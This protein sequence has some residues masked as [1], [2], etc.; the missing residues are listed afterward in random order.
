MK[1]II[2]AAF[3]AASI[4]GFSASA[5]QSIDNPITQAMLDVYAQ[6][7]A[8]NPKDAEL[9]FRRA[10]EY[11]KF[12]QYLRAL[13][14]VDK[15]L[16]YA[17]EKNRDLR[18]QAYMLRADI[19][20]MLNK[21]QE[22]LADFSQAYSID[23]TSFMA[24]YQKANEE[25]EL[26]DYT[27]A[28]ADYTRLRSTNPRSVEALTGLARVA[29]KE[30]NLGLA[31]EYMDGAVEMMSADSD[32]YVRRASVRRMQ[33]NNTGAVEDLLMAI[34]IDNN[35]RAFEE[36]I[37]LANVDY[38]AVISG[39]STSISYAPQQGMLYYIRG[40]IAQAHDH[41]ISA[42]EDYRR[43]IDQRMYDYAG[44]YNSMAQCQL[45]LCQYTDA[46]NNVDQAI[47]MA[48]NG[49]YY[50]T[51]AKIYF[52]LGKTDEALKML[53][54]AQNE[55]YTST[56]ASQFRGI[57]EFANKDYEAANELYASMSI[58]NPGDMSNYIYRAWVLTDGMKQSAKA[59]PI[60]SRVVSLT[61]S[62]SDDK[63]D[64]SALSEA[65]SYRGFALLFSG[66]KDE[67]LAWAD[68]LKNDY[69]DTDGYLS[70]VVACLYAQAGESDKAFSSLERALQ[71]GYGNRYEITEA[72]AGRVTLAPIRKDSR[73]NALL[74]RYSHLFE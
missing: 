43:L 18:F 38:P 14:D 68:K 52:A 56:A 47:S 32:I 2:T 72:T 54:K 17:P 46:M 27:A 44:L 71:L 12:N 36:L 19:Y 23:P 59:L 40:F 10:N 30:N 58:D 6:E 4:A 69:R 33:N 62:D 37:T 39:L 21:H 70:Y 66:K 63:S 3:V 50:V 74:A 5:Q 65:R 55:G 34:S 35:S 28:K 16:E 1:R 61:E 22:A 57:V 31:S 60:Y 64:T 73:F 48:S 9:Y 7:I 41:Y 15:T 11:Y 49:E 53:N 8:S 13:A 26:G 67:A 24:L 20:Q 51:K 29:V 42:L 25:Y 45:A